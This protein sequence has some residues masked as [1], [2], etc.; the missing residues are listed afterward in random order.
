MA[1]GFGDGLSDLRLTK[2]EVYAQARI[3]SRFAIG[4]ARGWQAD[5]ARP[6]SP[7]RHEALV[8]AVP[9]TETSI[10]SGP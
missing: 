2:L 6:A 1:F 5:G 9:Y 8:S 7:S 10:Q 4:L 3:Q